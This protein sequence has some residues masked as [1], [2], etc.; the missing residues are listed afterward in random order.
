MKEKTRRLFGQGVFFTGWKNALVCI[1][2]AAAVYFTD[3]IY[4]LLNHGPAVLHLGTALDKAIPVVPIFVIPYV[5]L[6]LFVYVSLIL[7]LLFRTRIFQAACLTMIAA[8]FVSYGFYFFLQSEMIR[9]VLSGTDKLTA[10]I[11][12]VYAGDNPYNCFPSLHTSISTI[13]AVYWLRVN[14]RLGILVAVWVA[15][16]VAS[17]VLIKQHYLADLVAGLALAF[18]AVWAVGKVLPQG[19]E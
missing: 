9:P 10:M 14:R 5:S 12:D 4:S 17:T 2:L 3:E 15:L 19:K 11:R 1:L 16:I 6:N 7:F 18:A 8:W 13:L